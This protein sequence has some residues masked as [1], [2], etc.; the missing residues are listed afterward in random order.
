MVVVFEHR[1]LD[2]FCGGVVLQVFVS[3][4]EL[5]V[6]FQDFVLD[7]DVDFLLDNLDAPNRL[8]V[9]ESMHMKVDKVVEI[10][11]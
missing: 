8:S 11:K 4:L 6:F 3:V 1:F 5:V 9:A 7:V 2:S 10:A